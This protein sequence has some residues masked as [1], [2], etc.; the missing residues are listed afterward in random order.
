M[1]AERKRNERPRITK[2][3]NGGGSKRIML[4]QL[5]AVLNVYK[6]GLCQIVLCFSWIEY[7]SESGQNSLAGDL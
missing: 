5:H 7:L 3:V 1:W 4:V 6:S 2:H